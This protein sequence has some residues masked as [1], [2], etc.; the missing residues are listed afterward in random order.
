MG[1]MHAV[2]GLH[3]KGIYTTPLKALSNQKYADLIPT[4]GV[5]KVGLS[6]GDVSIRKRTARVTV[7]TTE[8][9]RNLA[10]RTTATSNSSTTT[11][12]PRRGRAND[13][14]DDNDDYDDDD[15]GVLDGT[16]LVVFDEFHYMGNPGRGGAW[17]ES[18]ITSPS[19]VQMIA[20]SA[21]LPNAADLRD[22][23]ESVTNRTTILVQVRQQRP[24]PL[25]YLYATKEGL[26]HLFRDPDAGP[27]SPHGLLGWR[28]ED[29]AEDSSESNPVPSSSS[30]LSSSKRDRGKKA[31]KAGAK[32]SGSGF[33]GE[34]S[35]GVGADLERSSSATMPRG[36]QVNP[37]LRAAAEKRI[38]RVNRSIERQKA[39]AYYGSRSS[40][41]YNDDG[42][43]DELS[44]FRSQRS[45]SGPASLSPREERKERER[46]LRNEL[47][48]SVPS[49][50]ALVGRLEQKRLLPAIFFI[51]SRAGCDDAAR[52]LARTM[53]GPRD[54]SRLDREEERELLDL[55]GE[56]GPRRSTRQRSARRQDRNQLLQDASGR[57]FR[58][59]SNYLSEDVFLS[60][61][62]T[63]DNPLP[64]EDELDLLSPL[65]SES[66]NF[67]AAAGLLELKQVQ[68]VAARTARFNQENPEIAFDDE[69]V[70]QF[71]LGVGAHHAGML[72]A[73]KSFVEVLYRKQLMKVVFATETL[74]AG[75]NM[76]ARTTVICALAKR[77]DGSS[78]SLLETSNLLQMA[79]R[80][81]RRGMDTDGTC[82][83]VA[84]PFET[85]D[86]AAKILTDPI[87]PITSQFTPSYSLCVNLIA[88]G[89]GKLD[90]ARQLVGKSF[91]MWE[92]SRVERGLSSLEGGAASEILLI[93]A[94][95]Q[96][97]L[98]LVEAI[99]LQIDRRSALF[100]V[101]KLQKLL[102]VFDDQDLLK[103][104]SK[105]FI[106]ASRVLELEQT[107]L[108]CLE[109]ELGAIR[110]AYTDE[111]LGVLGDIISEDEQQLI[112]QIEVQ[113]RRTAVTEKEV[114]YHPFTAIARAAN[115]IMARGSAEGV[116][117]ARALARARRETE[118][119][120]ASL[121]LTPDE[122]SSYS[123][124]SVV[125]QRK[126]RKL[127]LKSGLDTG[128]VVEASEV[129]E[130]RD[131]SWDDLLAIT[132]TLVS[133]GC[134]SI[135]R[136]FADDLDL[137]K[138]TYAL[139]P[140]GT[141]VAMLGFENSLWCVVA[142]GGAWD[143]VSASSRLDAYDR[144][145]PEYGDMDVN[146]SHNEDGARG[147]NLDVPG[148]QK[149]AQTLVAQ[150]R[151]LS[152]SE[153]A[154][155]VSCLV[156]ES[157]NRLDGRSVV[158]LFQRLTSDQQR[159]VQSSLLAMERLMEVQKR[160]SVDE[161]TRTCSL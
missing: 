26:F 22:W 36:L 156:S 52:V 107:T 63:A 114:R 113:R 32:A 160:Y 100:D 31:R 11:R 20:L 96:F 75:I 135:D 148:P 83:I 93:S 15:A 129:R 106:G 10:W 19:H 128:S 42:E 16:G 18:V 66:W 40:R 86:D 143:V 117:L 35:G 51:F 73:H 39:Q 23:M 141:N 1:L 137:E 136:P 131:D 50:P 29:A 84:T 2:R 153:L 99:Q 62:G 7:M 125:L 41:S 89:E 33:G 119:S 78:M 9:Y 44:W 130:S 70:E 157:S 53:K 134:L 79:G 127:A 49:L 147:A 56:E 69:V 13:D 85:H 43:D 72:P 151:G 133:Y 90:V 122:L 88:R 149:E 25:R 24:V 118:E 111:D 17:E 21:T 112:S 67:Y 37:A 8:V 115:E 38:Q 61:Y 139:T 45:R 82:V 109:S 101:A 77:G 105:S 6:T 59:S 47:R 121:A 126:A 120:S 138:L 123:K 91:A 87:K 60:L 140:A 27:G 81:G 145:V 124:S 71:L 55:L 58:P 54:P 30:S 104:T 108:Q 158:D 57:S 4:F 132:R 65:A 14:V 28:G 116:S 144:L 5:A 142:I 150:L 102:T 159:V 152:S 80:A 48:R 68:E 154:G 74:A 95:Q 46:L 97:L 110:D 64:D 103:K 146:G 94:E 155:Y 98:S 12:T 34:G 3:Q 161:S 92:R 76:P